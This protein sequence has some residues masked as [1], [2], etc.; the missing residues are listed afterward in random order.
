MKKQ[1][2]EKLKNKSEKQ[3]LCRPEV[4][5]LLYKISAKEK[6][7]YLI[8]RTILRESVQLFQKYNTMCVS[9]YFLMI[10]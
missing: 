1:N 9:D 2:C 4:T 6:K 5:P 10:Q 8:L 7:H 3:E